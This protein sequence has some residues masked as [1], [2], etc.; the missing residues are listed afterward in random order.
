MKRTPNKNAVAR[1]VVLT[2]TRLVLVTGGHALISE[3]GLPALDA[4]SKDA[5]K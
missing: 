4:S 1:L 5:G 3:V 2:E